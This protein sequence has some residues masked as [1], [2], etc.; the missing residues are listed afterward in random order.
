MLDFRFGGGSGGGYE[1]VSQEK[2]V[3]RAENVHVIQ[4]VPAK[5][6]PGAKRAVLG[7][8]RWALCDFAHSSP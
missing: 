3:M 7:L 6:A 4:S 5:Q 1:E 8:F 2:M